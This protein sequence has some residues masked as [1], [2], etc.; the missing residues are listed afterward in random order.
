[1]RRRFGIHMRRLL[2]CAALVCF[3][4]GLTHS[5][6][7]PTPPSA[8]AAP[9]AIAPTLDMAMIKAKLPADALAIAVSAEKAR[10]LDATAPVGGASINDVA[11]AYGRLAHEFGHATAVAPAT[12]VVLNPS[13]MN[14]NVYD[15]LSA[16]QAFKLL[17]SSLDA[18]QWQALT[19]EQGLGLDSLSSQT[20]RELFIATIASRTLT[21]RDTNVRDRW[22]VQDRSSELPQA[23][24]RLGQ[25]PRIYLPVMGT[26]SFMSPIVPGK[27]YV[28]PDGGPQAEVYGV[29]VRAEVANSPKQGQLKF[30]AP[31]FHTPIPLTNL[32]TVGDLLARIGGLT[33]TELYADRHY[34]G[35][36]LT[37]VGS[38]KT[39]WAGDLLRAVALCVT[40]AYRQ[41]GR[42][43]VLTDDIVGVGTRREVWHEFE[44]D[45]DAALQAQ[46]A[47]ADEKLRHDFDPAD[48]PALSQAFALTPDQAQSAAGDASTHGVTS[49]KV[50]F[51]RLTEAQQAEARRILASVP[52]SSDG[53][54]GMTLEGQ[55]VLA[56]DVGLELLLP[57]LDAPA[58]IT[59]AADFLQG[60]IDEQRDQQTQAAQRKQAVPASPGPSLAAVLQGVAHRAVLANPRTADQVA[61]LVASMKK[62]GLNELWLDVFSE[63]V[64]RVPVSK[65]NMKQG[66]LAPPAD[67]EDVLAAALKVTKGT[68]IAVYPALDLLTWGPK[69]SPV[70]ADLTILG[71]TSAQADAR[72]QRRASLAAL[73]TGGVPPPSAP[74]TLAVSPFAPE[75]KAFLTALVG[76]LAHRSGVAG[77]VWR[78]TAPS[79]YNIPEGLS[80]DE[81]RGCLGYTQNARVQFLRQWHV[82]PVDINPRTPSTD[83]ANTA[84]PYF[85]DSSSA[86]DAEE[87]RL[88]AKFRAEADEALLRSLYA[89]AKTPSRPGGTPIIV[90]QR[91]GHLTGVW[92]APWD[93]PSQP[94]PDALVGFSSGQREA[95]RAK[96]LWHTVLL[97]LRPRG[98][99]TSSALAQ[100]IG[101]ALQDQPWNGLVLDLRAADST[102]PSSSAN[103]LTAIVEGAA[104]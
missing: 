36:T 54:S 95:A 69:T 1:M 65:D 44:A 34:E 99:T 6:A 41:V 13:P 55:I 79:G 101:N 17:L 5:F 61:V 26:E 9:A 30:D 45:A 68:G 11:G 57:G 7:A 35:Q 37:V 96:S 67:H 39:A 87:S 3:F 50:P 77:L 29:P 16:R 75:A 38:P 100:Q 89:E 93:L 23:R 60:Y 72:L 104:R 43:F 64:A 85:D 4:F 32:K 49:I 31:E 48:L 84:L 91:H 73:T 63:G 52:P 88:W 58:T 53:K 102:Q 82:D 19:S 90:A 70:V 83:R 78:E 10:L 27:Y 15:G 28:V 8:A 76:A 94:L 33:K 103:F 56:H 80:I 66:A 12:M 47:G 2:L 46:L 81:G 62:I 21:V 86:I 51:S 25:Q 71:E 24:L 14:P 22:E 18:A 74:P 98:A 20:Q 97:Q 92:Y 40:G 42:A 59:Q